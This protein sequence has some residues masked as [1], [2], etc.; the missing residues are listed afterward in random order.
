MKKI[1]IL[2]CGIL[3]VAFGTSLCNN[4]ALGIDPFNAFCAGLSV[5]FCIS[6]GTV[7]LCIQLAI[8]VFIY[9]MNKQYLGIGTIIPMVFYG[10]FLQFFN[11]FLSD[12]RAFDFSPWMIRILIFIAGMLIYA[13]GLSLY[14]GC[15]LGMVPYDCFSFIISDRLK[16]NA[17]MLRVLSDIPV[18]V[19]AVLFHGPVN[20]GT[21]LLA[22]GIGP[23]VQLFTQTVTW[24]LFAV[25]H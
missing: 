20:I 19:L 21:I 11:W 22:F 9:L 5:S 3:I 23:L 14:M 25:S 17:F 15:N 2:T 13:F 18:T 12:I 6:L 10:Y 7:T 8:A 4:T 1:F 24:R 16:K